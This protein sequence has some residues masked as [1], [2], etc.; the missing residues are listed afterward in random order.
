M[1]KRIETIF[2]VLVLVAVILLNASCGKNSHESEQ[3]H[4]NTTYV[5][6]NNNWDAI[7]PETTDN[8]ARS[9]DSTLVDNVFLLND[10]KSFQGIHTSDLMRW[11]N[12]VIE[13]VR[14]EN[15]YKVRGVGKLNETYIANK[16]D[17]Q[18]SIS[19]AKLGYT[20]GNVRYGTFER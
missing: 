6:G 18:D 7:W 4:H 3:P 12:I 13:S 16:Q 14:P 20:F 2:P 5:W 19:L 15:R 11:T 10:G 17:V 9:A 1:I 8:V